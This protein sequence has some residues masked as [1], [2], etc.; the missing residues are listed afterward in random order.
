MNALSGGELGWEDTF[1][2]EY[3]EYFE[4]VGGLKRGSKDPDDDDWAAARD[5]DDDDDGD[6]DGWEA[7]DSDDSGVDAS[8]RAFDSVYQFK[9]TLKRIR[10]PIWR[11]I[12]VPETYTFHDLHVAIQ[13]VMGWE[14]YHL[15]EFI[16]AN[17][18]TGLEMHIGTP[19]EDFDLQE[20]LHDQKEMIARYFTMEKQSAEYTYDFGDDWKHRVLL[21]KILPKDED[22]T[23]PVCIKGKRACPPEDCGGVWGYEELLEAL[24]DPDSAE[25]EELLEWLGEGFDPEYFDAKAIYFRKSGR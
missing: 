23:Y 9:I 8:K 25:N 20:I 15:H 13:D 17:P 14:G 21:E 3:G 22:A 10:P 2:E 5:D 7:D 24:H 12:Q 18:V 1:D 6:D 4:D 16:M 11:R 19:S